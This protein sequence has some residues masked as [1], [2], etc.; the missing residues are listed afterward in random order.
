MCVSYETTCLCGKGLAG[1]NFKDEIMSEEVISRLYCP[2]CSNDI[3]FNH[4]TMIADNGWV[5]E[6]DM[7][8]ARFLSQK[9]KTGGLMNITPEFIFDEGYCTWRGIYPTD[10]IDSAKERDE[11]VK[12]AKI[13]PR[14]YL[15][16]F[17][18]W[19]IARMDRLAKEGWRKANVR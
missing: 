14:K 4:E 9:I 1:F 2:Q 8:I 12:L 3:K 10:H 7:D 16:E 13:N 15:E 17:K 6:Y 18:K 19:G 11:I 5:I